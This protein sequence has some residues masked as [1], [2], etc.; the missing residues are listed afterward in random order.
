MGLGVFDLITPDGDRVWVVAG[1]QD[2]GKLRAW[3]VEDFAADRIPGKFR[4]DEPKSFAPLTL[5]NSS[6]ERREMF[7][8]DYLAL[9]GRRDEEQNYHIGMPIPADPSSWVGKK[10]YPYG[11]V[12]RTSGETIVRDCDT[13]LRLLT[14][15]PVRA[16]NRKHFRVVDI[17]EVAASW[18]LAGRSSRARAT[19]RLNPGGQYLYRLYDK[20]GRLLYVGITDNCFRRWKEHSKDKEWW[21]HVHQ[22]TQ[23]WYPDRQS[24]EA[25]ERRAISTEAPLFNKVHNENAWRGIDG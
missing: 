20:G 23:D 13:Y 17:W 7:I 24:V 11:G 4:I 3:T 22:F 2:D 19:P 10:I 25:A 1:W 9:N 21:R 6:A 16:N 12:R 15:D 5:I 14:I 8:G 18:H